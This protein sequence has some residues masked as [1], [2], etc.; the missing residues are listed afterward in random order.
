MRNATALKKETETSFVPESVPVPVAAAKPQ[1]AA[2]AWRNPADMPVGV[3][4]LAL[5]CWAAFLAVFWITFGISGNAEFMVAVSTVYAIVFF[6]VPVILTRMFPAEK[7]K[8]RDLSAFL[9]GRF[10]TL[11][12]PIRGF[13]ALVQVIIVPLAL[14]LG[15]IAIGFIIHAARAA[16]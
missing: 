16:H 5:A 3:H 1:A 8:H 2:G 11:Y 10:D 13:D 14:T 15:G 7:R 6:S 12:G 4:T 9:N